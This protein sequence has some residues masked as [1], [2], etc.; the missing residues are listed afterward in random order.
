MSVAESLVARDFRVLS[1]L[2]RGGRY[3]GH[4]PR[5]QRK[6]AAPASAAVTATTAA[7]T[8]ITAATESARQARLW[9]SGVPDAMRGPALT[10]A[11]AISA[12]RDLDSLAAWAEQARAEL[13]V[14]VAGVEPQ[15]LAEAREM[16][17]R[18]LEDIGASELG[19]ALGLST[20][21]AIRLAHQSRALCVWLPT[22]YSLLG[23]GQV[24][25]AK[26]RIVTD[27]AWELWN[28]LPGTRV[29]NPDIMSAMARYDRIVSR[30]IARQSHTQ[31][32]TVVRSAIQRIA[33]HTVEERH[34][35]AVDQRCVEMYDA[36]NGMSMLQA[37]LPTFAA[38]RVWQVLEHHAKTAPA[39]SHEPGGVQSHQARMADALV[40]IVD[41]SSDLSPQRRYDAAQVHVVVGLDTLLGV[42][43]DLA[44]IRGTDGWLTA[45][46]VRGLA[47]NSALRRLIVDDRDGQL[48]E[49]GRT[50]YR[51][52]VALRDHVAA[53]DV[54][55]RAPGCTRPAAY[56]DVDHIVPWDSDGAT[57]LGNL[58]SLCRRHHVLKT[59]GKWDYHLADDGSAEWVLPSG[60]TAV[61]AP[62]TILP[63]MDDPPPF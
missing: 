15:S 19:A 26:M 45:D 55:C 62:N 42:Q 35:R 49:Y 3:S 38:T 11:Q 53:R 30:A 48:L 33:A 20:N 57:D 60:A 21:A 4:G 1:G 7:V 14:A 2:Y 18:S 22:V 32:R 25:R 58:A 61:D 43:A 23:A 6:A 27:G 56:C 24:T 36:G 12:L 39:S 16:T 41:G 34:K 5:L 28:Y 10:T 40:S 17:G 13:V 46:T 50:T 8:R 47:V 54:T 51:P 29:T 63:V 59:F 44:C 9:A 37:L 52:P 31:L